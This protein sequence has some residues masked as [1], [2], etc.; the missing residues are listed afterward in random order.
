ML[1]A[2]WVD[3]SFTD[4]D[5][6]HGT[7]GVHVLVEDD[8]EIL[9]HGSVVERTL[10]IDGVAVRTGYVEAVATWPEHQRRGFATLVMRAIGDIIRDAYELGGLSTPVPDFYERLG[11]E[12]WTGRTFV[13]TAAATERTADDDGGI[14]ILRTPASPPF[15]VN[16]D[17]TCQWRSGDVW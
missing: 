12:L 7:G 6:E 15:D 2:A 9:S 4:L 11:W 5:W 13:R 3:G 8:G 14:M 16:A 10:E 17:I 1:A